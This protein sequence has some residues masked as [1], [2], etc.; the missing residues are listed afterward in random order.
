MAFEGSSKRNRPDVEVGDIVYA[1]LAV[2]SK[3]TESEL[4]CMDSFGKKG[5]LGVLNPNAMFFNCSLN[6][7]RKILRPDCPLLHLLSEELKYEIAVGLNGKIWI[8][9]K[10]NVQDTIAIAN[11]IL[12]AEY[13]PTNELSTLKDSILKSLALLK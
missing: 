1:K 13:T 10:V 12:A 6:L 5:K 3:D 8:K 4:V 11:A 7:I 9:S 2:A